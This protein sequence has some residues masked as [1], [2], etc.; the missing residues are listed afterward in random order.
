[1]AQGGHR[2]AD[3]PSGGLAGG[4]G[5]LGY[6]IGIRVS[7]TARLEFEFWRPERI[8]VSPSAF[9]G[10]GTRAFRDYSLGLSIASEFKTTERVRPYWLLGLNAIRVDEQGLSERTAYGGLLSGVGMDV[11]V[12]RHLALNLDAR[13]NYPIDFWFLVDP[14]EKR[15][16]FRPSVGMVLRF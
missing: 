11:N 12:T 7:D 14:H 3:R 6:T 4:S 5:A 16:S 8:A 10:E 9:P 1:M 13:V 15:M 2:S